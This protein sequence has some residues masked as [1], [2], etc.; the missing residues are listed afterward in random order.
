MKNKTNAFRAAIALA[1]CVSLLG[2]CT[3]LYYHE[4]E[5]E[6]WSEPSV[7]DTVPPVV[8]GENGFY[9]TAADAQ[10]LCVPDVYAAEKGDVY[11]EADG[12]RIYRVAGMH[13]SYFLCDEDGRAYK[14][15]AMRWTVEPSA[16]GWAEAYPALVLRTSPSEES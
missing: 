15:S 3:S 16:S 4:T 6:V 2:G 9:D 11:L 14:N 13:E 5:S 12:R 10:F 7:V 8:F 1:A